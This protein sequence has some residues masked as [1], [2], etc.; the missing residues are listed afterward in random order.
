MKNV[1]VQLLMLLLIAASFSVSGKAY[2][3]DPSSWG[4]NQGTWFDPWKSIWDIPQ[5]VGYFQPGDSIFFKS[6]H[7]YMGT[8]SI[9][10]SGREGAPIVLMP[11]GE[12]KTPVFKYNAGHFTDPM[13]YNRVMIRL[14]QCNYIVI[15][16]FELTDYTIRDYDRYSSANV[17]YGVYIYKG[18]HNIVKNC[19]VSRLG[20]GVCIDGG[21]YNTVTHCDIRNLRM[22]I[23]TPNDPWDDFGA[24]GIMVGGS[25][26]NIT[27]NQIHDCW[28]NSYDYKIDGGAVEMYGPVC[29]NRILYNTCSENL[30][31]MEFGSGSGGQ[32]LN[33]VVGY[34]LLVNNGHIFWINSSS[35]YS[36]DV[37]NLQFLNNNIVETHAPRIPEVRNLIGI[38]NTPTVANVLT[39]KNNI[40]WLTTGQNITDPHWQPF[41]GPQLIHQNN[42]F[43]LSGGSLGYPMDWSEQMLSAGASPFTDISSYDPLSWN[44]DLRPWSVAVNFGQYIGIDKDFF[45][46]SVPLSG[47]PDVGIAENILG[48]QHLEI[49]STRAYEAAD[50]NV[51]EWETNNESA[52]HFEL[53]KS[54]DGKAFTTVATI[55]NK[56]DA[57]AALKF[58]F[59]DNAKKG[60]VFYYRVKAVERDKKELYSKVVTIKNNQ[61]A[62]SLSVF[63]N[64][65]QDH[66]YLKLPG[67]DFLNKE[68]QIVNMAGVVLKKQ[69]LNE[70]GSQVKLDISSLPKGAFAI[71]MIDS[72]TGQSQSSLFTK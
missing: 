18:S 16:G 10:S 26:N 19:K 25:H 5:N 55:P 22:I 38:M 15:D 13:I 46:K 29:N 47:A 64:P 66:V 53:Q 68:I 30:G 23:N 44:Y 48:A 72:K 56:T 8:L 27:Y 33:N 36:L 42:L 37:R 50:G 4:S 49:V 1:R 2:F 59:T 20:S 63:P 40:F 41:N 58:H 21:S 24:M 57:V 9:N 31:F 70:A 71:K 43:H 6:G 39:M 28:A 62:G 3:V 67:F 11:Y 54:T 65:A 12:G 52:N 14:N 61:P 32:A 17:G 35:I 51:V 34:N 7:E 69:V 45:G 60:N